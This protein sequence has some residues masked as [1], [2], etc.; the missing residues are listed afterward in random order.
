MLEI[1]SAKNATR[2]LDN[3]VLAFLWT[4]RNTRPTV[5]TGFLWVTVPCGLSN[6]NWT[7]VHALTDMGF[8]LR[9]YAAYGRTDHRPIEIHA[10]LVGTE[11]RW[12]D[13]GTF[14]C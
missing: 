8:P 9:Y 4:I 7:G 13:C 1:G 10:G 14:G 11:A 3:S 6:P 12:R 2:T 5:S